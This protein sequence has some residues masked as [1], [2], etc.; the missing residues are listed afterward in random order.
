LNFCAQLSYPYVDEHTKHTLSDWKYPKVLNV[1]F[2][3]EF[4]VTDITVIKEKITN[5]F[6]P[7]ILI[8]FGYNFV[9]RD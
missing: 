3:E 7:R 6:F 1:K 5:R 2:N 9:S 8:L 4:I